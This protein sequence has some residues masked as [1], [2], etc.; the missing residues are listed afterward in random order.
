MSFCETTCCTMAASFLEAVTL[1]IRVEILVGWL[2]KDV[3]GSI[4]AH[5]SFGC[6]SGGR[7][8]PGSGDSSTSGTGTD[9]G[10]QIAEWDAS[11]IFHTRS[12]PQI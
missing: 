10:G 2:C 9:P 3:K 8:C 6:G 1:D 12:A 7:N 5:E 11:T 4:S